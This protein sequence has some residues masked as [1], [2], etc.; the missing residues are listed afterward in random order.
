MCA[1]ISFFTGNLI[2]PYEIS[3]RLPI[4]VDRIYCLVLQKQKKMKCMDQFQLSPY[5][6][7]FC[8]AQVKKLDTSLYDHYQNCKPLNG[9][10][11]FHANLA[12]KDS[13]RAPAHEFLELPD[14]RSEKEKNYCRSQ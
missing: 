4:N 14:L 3:D 11:R 6:F 1:G 12:Q 10:I 13:V 2:L 9:I 7:H 5:P 8:R